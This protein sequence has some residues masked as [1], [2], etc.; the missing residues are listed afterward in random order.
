[1]LLLVKA[2][3]IGAHVSTKNHTA[4]WNEIRNYT[5]RKLCQGDDSVHDRKRKREWTVS[6]SSVCKTANDSQWFFDVSYSIAATAYT[7]K[8]IDRYKCKH[9]GKS[10][11]ISKGEEKTTQV[12]K[13]YTIDL[14]MHHITYGSQ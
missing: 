7:I 1:M 2:L 12:L 10:K 11:S 8:Y 6:I 3:T 14:Y 5:A 9:V 13:M 4:Y